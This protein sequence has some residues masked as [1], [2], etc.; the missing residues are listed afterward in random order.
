M[1]T[2]NNSDNTKKKEN[3]LQ[4]FSQESNDSENEFIEAVALWK[5]K[6]DHHR[7][8]LLTIVIIFFVMYAVFDHYLNPKLLSTSPAQSAIMMENSKNK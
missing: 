8:N 6:I 4:N 1:L 2:S 5:E 7:W 3:D